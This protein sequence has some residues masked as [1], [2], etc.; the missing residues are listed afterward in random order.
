MIRSLLIGAAAGAAGTTALNAVT[1]ADMAWRGRAESD[2]PKQTVEK[3][4]ERLGA[5]VPGEGD[6]RQNRLAGLGALAGILTG[7]GVGAAYGMLDVLQLRPAGAP[8]ALLAAGGA[9]VAANLPMARLGI[10]DPTT[11]SAQDWASDVIPHLAYGAVLAAT[12]AA[13]R[14]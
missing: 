14:D 5:P 9:L 10:T 11:W 8:G 2:T 7:V 12:F 3:L 6:T 1:Y 13:A 4:S